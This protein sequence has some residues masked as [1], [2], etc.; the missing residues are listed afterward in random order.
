ME[1][2]FDTRGNDKQKE[3]VRAWVDPIKTHI[4]YGGSKGCAKSYTGVSLIFGN[5]FMYPD[6]RY[7]IARDTLN[8]LVKY[9]RPSIE[10]VFQHW[11]ITEKMW[12]Y[13]GQ[14]NQYILH[15]KSVI[16]FLDAKPIP[17]DPEFTRFGSMQ[18][19]QGWYEEAGEA[20]DK[21]IQN[22]GASIGRW[23]NKQYGLPYKFLRTCNPSKKAH[24]YD[25]FYLKHKLGTLEEYKCFI[26]GYPTDNKQL[27]PGYLENLNRTLSYNAKQRLLHG[28]WEFDDSPDVL[29]DYM[30]IKNSF[31]NS[32]VSST[33]PVKISADL[34]TQ[35]RD[36]FVVAV[37]R[38][39]TVTI[40]VD[41]TKSTAKSNEE[42]IMELRRK[43]GVVASNVV[44]DSDGIGNYLGSYMAG[45]NEFHG[46]ARANDSLYFNL[47]SECA[48]KLAEKVN[49]GEIYIICTPQQRDIIE[50]ELGALKALDIDGDEKRK[51]IV[52]KEEM[53]EQLQHSPDYLDA[54]IMGMLFDVKPAA[55]QSFIYRQR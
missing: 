37:W 8:D 18:F 1:I 54:L 48:Y 19:T 23:K 3:V 33:G 30:A 41:K 49:K 52:A 34:A 11:G 24:L 35:G 7:F 9:T 5:A 26:Q 12:R 28:N 6:T 25:E 20:H 36:R 21:A 14:L 32:H 44:A 51:R 40:E 50:S 27:D 10:E 2:V 15:N 38:G 42:D 45:I 53:K 16:Q 39:N 13:N 31:T 55:P 29:C 22:L 4:V 17:S 46:G 47:K 43:Y